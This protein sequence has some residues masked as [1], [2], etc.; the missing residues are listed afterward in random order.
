MRRLMILILAGMTIQGLAAAGVASAFVRGDAWVES[1]PGIRLFVREVRAST[2]EELGVPVLLIHGAGPGSLANFDSTVPSYSLAEDI[3]SVGHV[4]YMM[5]VRGSATPPSLRR[6]IRRIESAPPAV[7]SGEAV[8][9]ISAVVNWIVGRS[10]EKQ[11][12][13]RGSRRRRTLGRPVRGEK[14]RQGEPSGP[15]QHHVRR[16][17]ALA[18]GQN[19][20][21]SPQPRCIQPRGRRLPPGRCRGPHGRMGQ[22]DTCRGQIQMA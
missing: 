4:V 8:K 12:C 2:T 6:W 17:G 9:D 21:R 15:A 20:C 14:Q 7:S 11:G 18:D 13:S 10:R 1:E 22:G 16:Q 19:P 5:D 3:A